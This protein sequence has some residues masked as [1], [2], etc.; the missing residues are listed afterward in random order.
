MQTFVMVMY[1]VKDVVTRTKPIK[2]E[3]P[4]FIAESFT[5]YRFQQYFSSL[6]CVHGTIQQTPTERQ[7]TIRIL[8]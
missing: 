7:G 8:S 2:V 6:K 5:V 4:G 1:Q 3:L